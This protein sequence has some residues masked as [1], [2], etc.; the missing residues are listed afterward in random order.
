MTTS[1]T[2]TPPVKR[3]FYPPSPL[4]QEPLAILETKGPERRPSTVEEAVAVLTD[5][6][7]PNVV[8]DLP[9]APEHPLLVRSE[10]DRPQPRGYRDTQGGMAVTVGRV[11]ECPLLDLHLVSV[12]HNTLRGA[13]SGSIPNAETLVAEGYVA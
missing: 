11:R 4:R 12:S 3:F 2:G 10:P 13:A 9:S 1:S 7:G 5:F 6:R 8:R